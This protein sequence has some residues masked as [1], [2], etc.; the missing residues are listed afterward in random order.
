MAMIA[1]LAFLALLTLVLLLGGASF[2]SRGAV[3]RGAFIVALA[4]GLAAATAVEIYP[5]LELTAS[6]SMDAYRRA[7]IDKLKAERDQLIAEVNAK[8]RDNEALSKTSAFFT[9]LHKERMTRIA[10]EI[11]N[12][13]E[14]LLGPSSGLISASLSRDTTLTSFVEG[15]A[16]FESIISDLRNLK[17]MHIRGADEPAAPILAMAGPQRGVEAGSTGVIVE[18]SELKAT[19]TEAATPLTPTPGSATAAPAPAAT[20]VAMLAPPSAAAAAKHANPAEGETLAA[21]HKALDSQMATSA[22]RVEPITDPELITDHK[23]RYYLI[24]LRAPKTGQSFT[25][26]SGKYTLQSNRVEYKQTFNAFASDVL[27][28]LEGQARFDLYVRGSADAQ[29]YNGPYEPGYEIKKLAYLPSTGRGQ[30]LANLATVALGSTVRNLDLPNLRGE[31]LRS[32]LA[33]LYPQKPAV[34]LEGQVTKK[35][36]P[37][38]RNTELILFIAW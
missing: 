17:S 25:F 3:K 35:D 36:N 27:K 16:G 15:P 26:D 19:R 5:A 13:R 22:Y 12:A 20:V 38:A 29:H 8:A 28:Q 11:R 24:E 6:N 32:Y 18:P 2:V 30:Y 23:G 10:E 7:E 9:K 21:L 4:A 37:A 33:S 34:L 31:F 1:T 14:I